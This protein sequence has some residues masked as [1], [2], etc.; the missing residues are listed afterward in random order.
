M[1]SFPDTERAPAFRLGNL[2]AEHQA[3]GSLS[4]LQLLFCIL[5]P[6]HRFR[7]VPGLGLRICFSY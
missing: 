6:E 2:E 3:P 7:P 5:D 1:S 4:M